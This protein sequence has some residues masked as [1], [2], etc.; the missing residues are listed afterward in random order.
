MLLYCN[1]FFC[2]NLDCVFLSCEMKNRE[3]DEKKKI[4]IFN[5]FLYDRIEVNYIRWIVYVL[6]LIEVCFFVFICVEK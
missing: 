6:E 1:V 3:V 5:E 2:F 4:V